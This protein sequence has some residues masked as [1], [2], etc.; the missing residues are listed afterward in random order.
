VLEC[1]GRVLGLQAHPEKSGPLGLVLLEKLMAC[2][3]EQRANP[4]GCN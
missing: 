2:M 1:R 3:G 4:D